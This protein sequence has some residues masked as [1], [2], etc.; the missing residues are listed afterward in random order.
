M[1]II[2]MG[3]ASGAVAASSHAACERFRGTDPLITKQPRRDLA[4]SL[5]VQGDLGGIPQAR[6]VRAMTFESLVRDETFA[7]RIATTTIGNVGLERPK[8]VVIA[9][10]KGNISETRNQLEEARNRAIQQNLATLIHTTAIPHPGFNEQQ[11]TTVLPDFLIVSSDKI[12]SDDAW[13]IVGDAKDYERVRSSIEDARMLKGFVQVAFGAEALNSWNEL[14]AGLNIHQHGVLAVPRNSFLQPMAITE[15]LRD[16]RNE[17]RL[18]LAERLEEAKLIEF[19]GDPETYVNHLKASFDPHSC[20]TCPLFAHCRNQLRVSVEPDDFLSE[21]GIAKHLQPLVRGLV[22]GSGKV[23]SGASASLR[24]QVLASKTGQAQPTGQ[25]RLDPI[26]EPGT[27][28]VVLVK[29]D[30]AAL[31]IH[32]IGIQVVTEE[33]GKEWHFKVFS[34]PQSDITRREVMEMLGG[35]LSAA[36]KLTSRDNPDNRR[37]IHLIV[38]DRATG[39]ILASIAD[40]LAG[41]EISRLRWQRDVDMGREPL[42]FDGNPAKIPQAITL[43]QRLA[44]SFLL[45]DDRA[46]AFKL[47]STVVDIRDAITR[48]CIPG[49]PVSNYG[50]LDFLLPWIENNRGHQI[51]TRAFAD[52][53]EASRFTPGAR[54]SNKTSDLINDALE[55]SDKNGTYVELVLEALHF[56]ASLIDQTLIALSKFPSSLL[57]NALCSIEGDAQAV[58]RR[59]HDLQAND[60]IRFSSTSRSWRNG[61]VPTIEADAKCDAQLKAL[62]MPTWAEE[63]ARDAG[64]REIAMAKVVS[65]NPLTLDVESRRMVLGTRIVALHV[66]EQSLVEN[67]NHVSVKV[68]KGHIKISGLPSGVLTENGQPDAPNSQFTWSCSPPY[69]FAKGDEIVVAD[70]DWFTKNAGMGSINVDRPKVDG[71]FAPTSDCSPETFSENPAEHRWCCKPHFIRESEISDI[72]AQRRSVGELNP[73]V[74]PPVMDQDSFDVNAQGEPTNEDFQPRTMELPASLSMD[75]LE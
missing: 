20:S 56:R 69:K 53:I 5:S 73:E 35:A 63:K 47:R 33:G 46:R 2:A 8:G 7:S 50:R 67:N 30:A 34:V 72:I 32:G 14:P 3:G 17:V 18:R 28:N 45:E 42:T 71:R 4:K 55:G 21:L 49:G 23:S 31:G 12:V 58:W 65:E 6:W 11:A 10:A 27:V 60:L 19:N 54:L 44:V 9:D 29:S 59:R 70:F 16:H 43:A 57:R 66:N 75:D 62:T 39:D 74:W 26:G 36:L 68:L 41:V 64:F 13:I 24:R 22:D 51:D 1:G 25:F 15:D 48:L 61:L 37:P 40:S 38:P 52:S